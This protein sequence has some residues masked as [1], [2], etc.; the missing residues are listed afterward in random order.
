MKLKHFF[1]LLFCVSMTLV[2]CDKDEPTP[3][4]CF[5]IAPNPVAAGATA[6]FTSC[7][8]DAHHFE[9]DFGDSATS[10]L[11]NPTHVY[12]TPGTYTVAQHVFNEDMSKSDM[13]T[14][15]ITVN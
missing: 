10:D 2:A 8:T 14:H 7:A 4:A 1:L 6:T 9:W 11:E 12:N 13:I 15:T 3:V 5:S